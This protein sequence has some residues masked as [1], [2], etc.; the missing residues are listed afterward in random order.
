MDQELWHDC[1]P[2]EFPRPD[3]FAEM[4]GFQWMTMAASRLPGH[5]VVLALADAREGDTPVVPKLDRLAR[6]VFD[7]HAIADQ[8]RKRGVKLALGQA[9]YAPGDPR[10]KM[11]FNILA[12]FP[13]F[14]ADVIRMRTREGKAIAR[15]KGK[16][17]GKQSKP[18]D[19]QQQELCR[20]HATDEYSINDLAELFSVSRPTVYST[21]NRRHSP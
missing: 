3:R 12:T 8:L 13:E 5:A 21:L 16:L 9:L 18:S 17:R 2:G 7:A 14:E 6:S 11:F 1:Q 4:Y 19:R 15:A 20:M 10:E